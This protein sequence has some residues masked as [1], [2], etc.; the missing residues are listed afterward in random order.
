MNLIFFSY[1]FVLLF[2]LEVC[3]TGGKPNSNTFYQGI[4]ELGSDGKKMVKYFFEKGLFKSSNQVGTLQEGKGFS[5]LSSSLNFFHGCYPPEDLSEK[6]YSWSRSL[7]ANINDS[8]LY[9]VQEMCQDMSNHVKQEY[10]QPALG[11]DVTIGYVQPNGQVSILNVYIEP[12]PH[13]G[14]THYCV[15]KFLLEGTF[16]LSPNFRIDTEKT[17]I[18]FGLI[19]SSSSSIVYLPRGLQANDISE[20]LRIAIRPIQNVLNF[21][22]NL[23]G[24]DIPEKKQIRKDDKEL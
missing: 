9:V 6:L 15:D 23:L 19:E 4:K 18:C 21:G 17:S 10:E 1:L 16:K 14:E 3:C 5:E 12:Y 13:K 8:Q 22:E 11:A 24:D 20:Y 7:N 2:S